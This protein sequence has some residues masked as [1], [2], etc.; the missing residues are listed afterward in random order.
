[1]N[2]A[3]AT[4]FVLLA[5]V[6]LLL[7]LAPDVLLALFAGLLLA[8]ALRAAAVPI[9]RRVPWVGEVGAVL[10]VSLVILVILGTGAWYGASALAEEARQFA[11]DLPRAWAELTR[12]LGSLPG[13]D[14]VREMLSGAAPDAS[15]AA[16]AA[17]RGV[18]GTF[19]ALGTALLVL[20]VGIYLAADPE[21]YRGG[22]LRL[23]APPLRP[24]AEATL[25]SVA[26]TLRGW[27]LG[28]GFAM[29]VTGV[30][31]FLGLWA[32]GVPLAGLLSVITAIVGFIPYIGPIVGGL[33]AVLIALSQD[34]SLV[35]W[36]IAL[37]FVVQNVEGN[38]LTPL[39]QQR[40]ADVPPVLLLAAQALF[41][42]GVGIIGVV[43]AAPGAAAAM[44]AI[45]T[46][47]VEAWVEDPAMADDAPD[48]RA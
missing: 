33:P 10:G 2:H 18:S 47:Y 5:A 9:A 42:S 3:R 29:I 14:R 43:V 46:G 35:P 44:A 40:A 36:V 13:A 17:L 28:Q 24:R 39:V 45:R 41:G 26:D 11:D 20:I 21:T 23:L 19:G 16:S 7:W 25:D 37:F 32:L 30:L 15:G 48:A 31:T 27:L 34:P 1:M 38:I 8:I 6:A 4:L 22:F 12:R